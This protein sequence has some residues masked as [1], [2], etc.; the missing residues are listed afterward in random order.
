[1]PSG[2]YIGNK[3]K[4]I[5]EATKQKIRDKVSKEKNHKWKGVAVGYRGVHLWIKNNYGQPTTCEHCQTGNLFGRKIHWANKSHTYKRDR[6]DW[7]RLCTKCHGLF[8]RGH[9]GKL[10]A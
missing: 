6:E 7:L 1:M 2:I 5:S 10:S 4:K 9:R 8:D 3:G